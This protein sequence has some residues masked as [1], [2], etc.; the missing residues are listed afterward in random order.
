MLFLAIFSRPDAH[1]LCLVIIA[2]PNNPGSNHG[3]RRYDR[4]SNV[5]IHRNAPGLRVP[6]HRNAFSYLYSGVY[7]YANSVRA[8]VH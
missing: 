3:A 7:G 2:Q 5:T 1:A 4:S 8:D 6:A